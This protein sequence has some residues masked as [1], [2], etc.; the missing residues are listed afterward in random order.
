MR[1]LDGLAGVTRVKMVVA[2]DR[3]VV[4]IGGDGPTDAELT[5]AVRQLGYRPTI[6][7]PA[8]AET[9]LPAAPASGVALA[10]S[11]SPLTAALDRALAGNRLVLVIFG[12]QWCLPCERMQR[13]TWAS[14]DLADLIDGVE[15]VEIDAD[16]YTEV[17][18]RLGVVSLPDA[19]LLRGDGTVLV[20]VTGFQSPGAVREAWRTATLAVGSDE[21][22][23]AP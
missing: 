8:E 22:P 13:E 14:P 23:A 11:D 12:A 21:S 9:E 19:R 4:H 5:A 10:A 3:F 2:R 18:R 7:G 17:A 1:A 15:V 16:E 6:L 20:R